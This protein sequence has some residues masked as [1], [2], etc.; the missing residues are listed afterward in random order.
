MSAARSRRPAKKSAK[1]AGPP[2]DFRGYG[3]RPPHAQWP[4]GAR[5]ALNFNLN[6][7]AGG[8]HSICP[9][10]PHSEDLLTD[11][12]FPAYEGLVKPA[13]EFAFE[14]GYRASVAWRLLRIFE[15]FEVKISVLGVVR[16]RSNIRNR[17]RPSSPRGMK[18]SATAGAG[19]TTIRCRRTRSASISG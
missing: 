10:D 17:P 3:A 8:E 4:G 19:S 5:I 15:R 16:A 9:G 18:S 1:A 11:I 12:G 2:R 7:E 13:A 14:R 6:V